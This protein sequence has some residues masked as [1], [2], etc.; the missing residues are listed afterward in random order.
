[1]N[2]ITDLITVTNKRILELKDI[3]NSTEYSYLNY[4]RDIKGL[5]ETNIEWNEAAKY[6]LA[7]IRRL[8]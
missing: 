4:R 7:L 2:W 5:L 6:K 3:L 1:M 8:K